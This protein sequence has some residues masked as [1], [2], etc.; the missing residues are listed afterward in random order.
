[1]DRIVSQLLAELDGMSDGEEGGGGVFVIGATN[2][3]D[4]LD[5]AHLRPGR[6]DKM[7]YLGISDTH[8]KQRT[9]LEA[10]TRKF[11]L[12]QH[13]SLQRVASALPF[14][15]TGADLYALCSDSML[16]A[17]TRQARLVDAK[18]VA[19]N[20]NLRPGATQLTIAGFFDHYATDEDTEVVVP[21]E[22]FDSA[23][24][25]LVPSVTH[26]ELKHYERVRM[27]FEGN[28]D[29]NKK[30]GQPKI[31]VSPE[32]GAADAKGG[33]RRGLSVGK[34]KGLREKTLNSLH[35]KSQKTV[36]TDDDDEYTI[37]TSH[38][39][40]NGGSVQN[41]NGNGNGNGKLVR[42]V[43]GQANGKAVQGAFGD[44]AMD[45]EEE[46]YT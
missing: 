35:R 43:T 27:T 9:I 30:D 41:G 22:D 40:M 4:L 18:V 33:H 23:R 37:D 5:Q 16:K 39:S 20:K 26:E 17:I 1:M 13:L 6:F 24:Q 25:E 45:D 19:H 2:R 46:L 31:A 36:T 21:E 10:L 29:A 11:M 38:L 7:L 28:G 15:Y 14:T 32:D 12:D 42:K 34:I 44:A 8:E 3:P